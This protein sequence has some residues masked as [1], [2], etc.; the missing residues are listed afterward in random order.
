MPPVRIRER[1]ARQTRDAV[2]VGE[3]G[4]GDEWVRFRLMAHVSVSSTSSFSTSVPL[5]QNQHRLA[6]LRAA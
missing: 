3:V 5:S 6:D 2:L 1:T 4:Q